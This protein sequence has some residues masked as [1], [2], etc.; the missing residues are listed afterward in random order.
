MDKFIQT[1]GIQLHYLDFPGPDPTL[2][3]LPGL[4]ANAHAFSGLIDAGLA[5]HHHVLTVDL[6]GRGLSDKPATGYTM[7]DHAADIIALLDNLHLQDVMLVGH[8]F[9]GLLTLFLAAHYPDRFPRFVIMDAAKAATHPR[10][11]EMIKPSLARLGQTLP[12]VTAYLQAMKQMPFLNGYWDSAIESYYRADV[13]EN[14]DGT[15]QAQSTPEAIA[16]AI[17]GVVSEDWDRIFA[18]VKGTSILINA[19]EAYGP[20]GPIVT[21]EQAQET[22]VLLPHCQVVP[23]PGNH[24]TMLFGDHAPETT[25]AILEFI[26][27][28]S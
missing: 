10:V 25:A 2:L 5:D 23:V 18:G 24:F 12:S 19:S 6:R 17:D 14:E 26:G 11:A 16:A 7:A 22:A 27:K 21:P 3:L 28:E 13:R 9:G 1:N 20:A 4:T 15:A 8:S